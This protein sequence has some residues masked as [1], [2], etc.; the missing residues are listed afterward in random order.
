MQVKAV[1]HEKYKNTEIHVCK[2]VADEEVK[3]LVEEISGLVNTGIPAQAANGDHIT[4]N[5]KD[6]VRFYASGAKVY[7]T[8]NGQTFTVQKKFY[9]L[10]QELDEKRFLRI[11]KSE[12]VNLKKITRFNLSLSGTIQILL[13][14]GSETYT[15]RR[16]VVKLKKLLGVKAEGERSLSI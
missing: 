9:E 11:S 10:E 5:P 14:D 16:N 4:M 13:Q 7:A 3:G 15:S 12:I 2:S 6:A 8:V 1:I